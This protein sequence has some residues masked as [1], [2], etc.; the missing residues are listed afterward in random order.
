M[1]NNGVSMFKC[2]LSDQWE[3]HR[4]EAKDAI[5]KV[6]EMSTNM[7]LI[8][9]HTQHLKK[10][11]KLDIIAE[12]L[13]NAATGKD[14]MPTKT[15]HLIF[16]MFGVVMLGLIFVIVFLLTGQKLGVFQLIN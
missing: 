4:K 5:Y 9:E 2:Q 12:S 1:G 8:I 3:E 13:L 11:D 14:Q 7:G 10:L 6:D 15:A 16:K